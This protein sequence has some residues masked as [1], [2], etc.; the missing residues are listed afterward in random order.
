MLDFL[1]QVID[2]DYCGNVGVILFNHNHSEFKV[3]IGDRIAQL[4]LEKIENNALVEEVQDLVKTER[5]E[6]GF[7]STGIKR[8]KTQE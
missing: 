1:L 5:G 8:L 3:E 7:G 6:T 4:I 2:R